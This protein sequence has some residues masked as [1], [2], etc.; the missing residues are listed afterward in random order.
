MINKI[1]SIK[2]AREAGSLYEEATRPPNC[3]GG[4]ASGQLVDIPPLLVGSPV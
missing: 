2:S 4:R 3:V 1:G